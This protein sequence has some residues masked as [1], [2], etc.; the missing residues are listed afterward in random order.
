M[1][2]SITKTIKLGLTMAILAIAIQSNAQ[3]ALDQ[4]K[5][6]FNAGVGLSGWGIPIYAGL[7]FGIHKDISLG[8]DGSWRSYSQSFGPTSYTSSIIGLGGNANYH[9]N[10]LF[11][12][13]E[14][15]DL[16]AGLSLGYFIWSTSAGYSGTGASG[17]GFGGQIGGRYYFGDNFGIHLEGGGGNS[18]SGGKFGISYKF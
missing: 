7:D 10:S 9:F 11:G 6:Q 12:I 14:K 3:Y 17:L 5:M 18:T 2:K 4:G 16:Y 13:P 15:F 8:V 1:N